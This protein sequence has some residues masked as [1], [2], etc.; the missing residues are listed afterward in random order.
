MDEIVSFGQWLKRRRKACDLTQQELAQRVACSKELIA[1]IEADAR[2]PSKQIAE[3]LADQLGLAS[4]ER[5]SFLQA[6]RAQRGVDRLA[7]PSWSGPQP[8]FVPTVALPRR[9]AARR[10]NL[11]AQPTAL[12]GRE[13]ELVDV[14]SLLRRTD[15]QLVTLTGPGGVGKTRMALRVAAELLDDFVDGI[16]I[17][18]LAPVRDPGLV[19]AAI[20]RTLGVRAT[21]ARPLVEDLIAYLGTRQL[22][23]L[24]DN[25]EQVLEA[26]SD[27]SALRAGAPGL[28]LLVTS[29]TVLHLSGEHEFAVPALAFPDHAQLPPLEQLTQY[30]AVQFFIMRAQAAQASFAVTSATA[31]A[32]AEI[33]YRLDGL[34]LALE[35]AAARIKLFPPQ[36]LLGRLAS[37]ALA[38]LSG[39]AR[40]LPARQ[41]T[42]RATMSWSYD[43]LEE[44]EQRLF[45]RLAIFVGGWTLEAAEAV[46]GAAG[47]PS[48]AVLD[49]LAALVDQSLVRVVE[50]DGAPRFSMLETIREYALERLEASGEAEALRERH[51]RYFVELTEG[52]QRELA[53]AALAAWLDRLEAEEGNL[54]AA[55]G[56]S[57][58]AASDVD[59]E[60]GLRLAGALLK[61]WQLRGRLSEGRAQLAMA[62]SRSAA[63]IA[64]RARALNTAG[65]LAFQQGDSAAARPLYE[66]SL[67]I[68]RQLADQPGIAMALSSLGRL[69]GQQQDYARAVALLEESV[70]LEQSL[71]NQAGMAF[72]LNM[73]AWVQ[74]DP[75]RSAVGLERA[76]AIYRKLGDIEHM[77][78]LLNYL[79]LNVWLQGDYARAA[80]FQA[81]ALALARQVGAKDGI[82]AA[83]IGQGQIAWLQ[84]DYAR[85]AELHTESLAL[86]REMEHTVHI[87][88]SLRN[89]G[90]DVWAQGDYARATA[91]HQESLP[92]YNTWGDKWGIAECIEGLA[93][94][95]SSQGQA[96]RDRA[97]SAR[98]ARL[99]GGAATLRESTGKPMAPGYRA[100]NDRVIAETRV[101]LGEA[102][103]AAA[104]AEGRAMRLEQAIAEALMAPAEVSAGALTERHP[105]APR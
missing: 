83:L 58:A 40:D 32:I 77:L 73:L 53:S 48:A 99:F 90:A 18:D 70:A 52:A 60:V 23:L 94:A 84:G 103:F 86:A 7:A 69:A 6:A 26:A 25:F 72:S 4:G 95:A 76:L 22:L 15:T 42:L 46:C 56:W 87:A 65:Q 101:Q 12:I 13:R 71:G 59:A 17:V 63:P 100:T 8:A 89:L 11:P 97:L 51:A 28:K 35:L 31:Q 34:P 43:L 61:F 66:E 92:L 50:R 38:L 64:A 79:S 91:L 45:A 3:R 44:A 75:V 62:L 82:V 68:Y 54:R 19:V 37:G 39:G 10:T 24:L 2:R 36:A 47:E 104:W 67:A 29:R 14:T 105:T 41:Q 27:I 1:K 49:S 20:V 16:Y 98:A 33:C 5:V 55:L 88:I 96:T 57:H 85:A 9:L 80:A 21:D 30:A 81:E 78:P 93:W 74:N 102:A